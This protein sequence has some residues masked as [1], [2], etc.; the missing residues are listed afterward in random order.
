M[1]TG[2]G[3]KQEQFRNITTIAAKLWQDF[4]NGAESCFEL[5]FQLRKYKL[6]EPPHNSPYTALDNPI[7]W[8]STCE[9]DCN[10][11]QKLAIKLFSVT[12]HTASA[13]RTFSIL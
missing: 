10:H 7:N 6:N 8:W 11:L 3:L 2:R 12:P 13:E 9:D 1:E 4:D 5:L